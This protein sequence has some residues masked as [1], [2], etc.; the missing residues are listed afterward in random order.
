MLQKWSEFKL[1]RGMRT[2]SSSRPTD[3]VIYTPRSYPTFAH[4]HTPML[5]KQLSALRFVHR[6]YIQIGIHTQTREQTNVWL[7]SKLLYTSISYY[8]LQC[9]FKLIIF[10]D[11]PQSASICINMCR[12][13]SDWASKRDHQQDNIW[14]GGLVLVVPDDLGINPTY[15]LQKTRLI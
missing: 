7:Y 10:I 15:W 13:I 11:A 5:I 12:H 2:C 9:F 8:M 14:L 1:L 3:L 6:Y 4:T